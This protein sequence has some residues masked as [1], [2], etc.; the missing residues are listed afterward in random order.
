M[1][2][3]EALPLV[4]KQLHALAAKRMSTERKDHTL[5]PTALLHEAYARVV[6]PEKGPRWSSPGH[7][8]SAAAQA[9]RHVLI[10][11][12]RKKS[13]QKRG[14]GSHR[15]DVPMSQLLQRDGLTPDRLLELDDAIDRLEQEGG[16]IAELVRL[17]LYAGLSVTEAAKC[18]G[19]S[20]SVAYSSWEYALCWFSIE[21]GDD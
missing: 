12:A 10:D 15:I 9:M 13:S 20:R 11:H 8:Y 19:V 16:R 6:A 1:A 2:S 21:L 4:Y 17:R 7:F 5:Q 14:G 18:M 3:H